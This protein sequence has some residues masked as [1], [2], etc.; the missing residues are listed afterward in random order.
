MIPQWGYSLLFM[1]G[2][3]LFCFFPFKLSDRVIKYMI[4]WVFTAMAITLIVLTIVFTTER[5]FANRF[6]VEQVT[7]TLSHIYEAETGQ[8]IK[9]IGGFIEL[10]IPLSLYNQSKYIVVLNTY[11]YPN[12][13]IN[14]RD[15]KKSGA[16]IIGR[17]HTFMDRYIEE[18][19]P[20]LA[21]K[22]VIKLFRFTVK[23][24]VGKER[25]YKMF[26]AIIPPNAERKVHRY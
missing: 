11:K 25:E 4:S 24:V 6:P 9:Y 8:Q 23:S 26:Y 21:K 15:L 13:W 17:N 12:I 10:S 14:N 5:N 18:T 2:I 1:S 22:P 16:L 3:L 7:S 20:N 19:V